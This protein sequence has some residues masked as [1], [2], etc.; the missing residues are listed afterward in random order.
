V[1]AGL[2]IRQWQRLRCEE[3][4]VKRLREET[5]HLNGWLASEVAKAMPPVGGGK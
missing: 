5:C 2:L 1:I 4:M 3:Q